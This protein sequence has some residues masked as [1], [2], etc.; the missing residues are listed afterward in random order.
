MPIVEA[1]F[2]EILGGPGPGEP[3]PYEL[4]VTFAPIVAWDEDAHVIMG[5]LHGK[6]V[7]PAPDQDPDA[8][9]KRFEHGD[10]CFSV[11]H[12]RVF[13]PPPTQPAVFF[14]SP[15]PL[16]TELDLAKTLDLLF[17]VGILSYQ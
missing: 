12:K 16:F 10:I 1:A 14:E 11:G 9:W 17:E 5:K 15:G 8:E 7:T 13:D 2:R 6:P 4:S 3:P